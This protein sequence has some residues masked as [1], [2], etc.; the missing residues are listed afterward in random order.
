MKP[1]E[2]WL[3]PFPYTDLTAAKMRPALVLTVETPYLVLARP[4][5]EDA[6]LLAISSVPGNLG[7]KD[8]SF[9]ATDPAFPASGLRVPSVFKVPKLFTMHASLGRRRLGLL[10]RG[11]FDRVRSAVRACV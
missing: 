4:T 7:P 8:V 3:V 11:W 10:E 9:P 2:I 6:L 1:G 5:D